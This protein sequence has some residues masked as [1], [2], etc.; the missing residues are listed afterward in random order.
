MWKMTPKEKYMERRRL[1]AERLLKRE[2]DYVA[3]EEKHRNANK[4]DEE[5]H[6]QMK[7]AFTAL[8]RIADVMEL[9]ADKQDI[10]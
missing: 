4:E 8:D 3:T 9:W 10:L 7:R 2:Q 5:M 6:D 1:R